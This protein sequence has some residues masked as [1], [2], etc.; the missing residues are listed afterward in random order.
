M[1]DQDA[2]TVGARERAEAFLRLHVPG[3]PLL[4]V[5][6]WDAITARIVESLGYAAVATTSAGIALMEGYPDGERIGRDTMLA[7]IARVCRAVRV[8][9]TADVEGGYGLTVEDAAATARGVLAAGAVGLNFED[10]IAATGDLLDADLQAERIRAMRRVA[11]EAGV[12][13]VINARTDVFLNEIGEE[14]G[15]LD[16]ALARGR[17]YR[18]AGADCIFVPGVADADTIGNLV[19]GLGAPLNVLAHPLMPPVAEL[20]KLG[21]ARVS[22]GSRPMYVALT[23]FRNAALQ[24]RDTG[25]F[26]FPDGAITYAEANAL[27]ADVAKK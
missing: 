17:R 4:L 5:N 19:R 27:V 3:D 15:R 24:L 16:E 2:A 21:V 26:A 22:M 23:A 18:E 9:V 7:G 8:P 25:S 14:A 13:L 20:A 11:H 6:A 12:P 10:S 1:S